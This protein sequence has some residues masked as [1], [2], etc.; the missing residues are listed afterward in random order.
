M[1]QTEL[2]A[3]AERLVARLNA[4]GFTKNGKPMVIDQAFELV[5]AEEGFRNQHALRASLEKDIQ[6]A[7]QPEHLEESEGT[8]FVLS[9]A[10]RGV[11]INMGAATVHLCRGSEPGQPSPDAG[12]RVYVHPSAD[13]EIISA[14]V[15]VTA[16]ELSDLAI[17]TTSKD[18]DVFVCGHCQLTGDIEDSIQ[19]A[20]GT[21]WCESCANRAAADK[22]FEAYDFGDEV[23]VADHDGWEFNG[24]DLMSK[25]VFLESRDAPELPSRKVQFVVQVSNGAVLESSVN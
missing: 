9:P 2:K 3:R 25:T 17:G 19:R 14:E 12:V 5:A 8:D 22:A 13:L 6:L 23:A 18:D 24:Q 11:W 20:D 10:T 21:L 15:C 7:L 1:T 4:M 16:A